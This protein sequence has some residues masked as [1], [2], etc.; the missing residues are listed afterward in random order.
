MI[1]YGWSHPDAKGTDNPYGLFMNNLRVKKHYR[2]T[3]TNF[4]FQKT[5]EVSIDLKIVSKGPSNFDTVRILDDAISSSNKE[6]KILIE[7]IKNMAKKLPMNFERM[8]KRAKVT[9][10]AVFDLLPD[11]DSTLDLSMD[12]IKK[13]RKLSRELNRSRNP[14]FKSLGKT[15]VACMNKYFFIF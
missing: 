3:N 2:I 14:D 4:S 6:I 5:G 12:S 11:F 15:N 8:K 7:T 13:L 9:P 1:E 10:D